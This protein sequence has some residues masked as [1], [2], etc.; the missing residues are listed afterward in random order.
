MNVE[1]AERAHWS[2][3]DAYVTIVTYHRRR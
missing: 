3:A 1:R 2:M